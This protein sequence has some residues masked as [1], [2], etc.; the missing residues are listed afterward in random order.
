M[1]LAVPLGFRFL[2]FSLS[3]AI[4][5]S[6]ILAPAHADSS[7]VLVQTGE[8]VEYCHDPLAAITITSLGIGGSVQGYSPIVSAINEAGQLVFNA[9]VDGPGVGSGINRIWTILRESD[10]T[11]VVLARAGMPVQGL[12][13]ATLLTGASAFHARPYRAL[14]EDGSVL[15]DAYILFAGQA[16]PVRGYVCLLSGQVLPLM[17]NGSSA[18]DA[19]GETLT[20]DPEPYPHLSDSA[21]STALRAN[22][23]FGTSASIPGIWQVQAGQPPMLIGK[24]Y[25]QAPGLPAGV[26]FGQDIVR[27]S[28]ANQNYRRVEYKPESGGY[29]LVHSY[30]EGADVRRDPAVDALPLN[31]SALWLRDPSGAMSLILRAGDAV[32]GLPGI[33]IADLAARLYWAGSP[34]VLGFTQ[35]QGAVVT[36][37]GK[38]AFLTA[39]T[40][41]S[42][43]PELSLYGKS[44]W[45]NR[46]GEK[47]LEAR[48]G[49]RFIDS[50]TGQLW[51][52]YS[53]GVPSQDQPGLALT[54]SGTLYYSGLGYRVGIDPLGATNPARSL[55]IEHQLDGSRRVIVFEG[56]AAPGRPDLSVRANFAGTFVTTLNS[57]VLFTASASPIGTSQ[58]SRML[59]MY[60]AGVLRMSTRT[61]DP[62]DQL[63][64]A[65]LDPNYLYVKFPAS[66][67]GHYSWRSSGGGPTLFVGDDLGNLHTLV[68]PAG[69]F[70]SSADSRLTGLTNTCANWGSSRTGDILLFCTT[71]TMMR[72]VSYHPNMA[73]PQCRGD[74]NGDGMTSPDDIFGFL[75]AWFSRDPRADFNAVNGISVQDLYDF[76]D[77]WFQGCP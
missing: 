69:H 41:P 66:P 36:S 52:L 35:M 33:F 53:V 50:A 43:D 47:R 77:A 19:P 44:I 13:G 23:T 55:L 74:F 58:N 60:R 42:A 4:F 72:F 30:L 59:M 2:L 61:G 15:L 37:S 24:R 71:G 3:V 70:P 29:A 8:C 5:H 21:C 32:P 64:G 6:D 12:T 76:L 31:N 65:A 45:S 1:K 46:S 39:L 54:E 26:A 48:R 38:Y 14:F 62:V 7:E 34:G 11:F 63:G 10:G 27:P 40:D 28:Y 51:E 16:A 57:S 18:P 17:V 56:Q 75:N 68:D 25:A 9:V 49:E 73:A 67:L 22:Q 20:I